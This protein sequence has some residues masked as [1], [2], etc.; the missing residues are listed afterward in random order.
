MKRLIILFAILMLSTPV[1]A[2]SSVFSGTANGILGVASEEAPAG[3]WTKIWDANDAT[4][5]ST[6]A[7]YAAGTNRNSR[8]V[9]AAVD[10]A[11]GSGNYTKI[12]I[13]LRAHSSN[14]TDIGGAGIGLKKA[15]SDA[16]DYEASPTNIT[17]GSSETVNIS[18]GGTATSDEITF[19]LD[20]TDDYL[21]GVYCSD[22]DMQYLE[23]GV[24]DAYSKDTVGF[25]ESVTEN[26]TGYNTV[27]YV[28]WLD[29]V[30]GYQ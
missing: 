24:G 4:G 21:V 29:E 13:V 22:G 15:S 10:I 19:T 3:T 18:A 1:Y 28:E 12:K 26:V 25:D 30:W 2:G 20:P 11:N 23:G 14:Q 27:Q 9:L 8:I 5:D 7:D 16:F 17:F 6:W